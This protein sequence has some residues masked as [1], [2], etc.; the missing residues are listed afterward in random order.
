MADREHEIAIFKFFREKK[1]GFAGRTVNCVPGSNPNNPPDFI[2]TGED[3]KRIGVELG[4]WLN[5]GQMATEREAEVSEKSFADALESNKT[6]HPRNFGHVWIGR[7]GKARIKTTDVAQF[8]T[9]MYTLMEEI[10]RG[11]ATNEDVNGPQGLMYSDFS[12]FPMV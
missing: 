7:K 8:K 9:E 2:C 11:W 6:T 3:A 5:Q 10:D 4:E 12:R 1:P